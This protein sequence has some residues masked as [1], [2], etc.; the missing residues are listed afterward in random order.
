VLVTT[1]PRAGAMRATGTCAVVVLGDAPAGARPTTDLLAERGPA[2]RLRLAPEQIALLPSSSGTTG[3]P[4]A[5]V[6]THANL[7]AGIAQVQ[8]GFAFTPRDV[9]LGV[10]PFAHVMGFVGALAAPL[11]AGAT[12][13][14]LPRFAPAALLAAI[15]RY[16]VTVLIAPPP[17]AAVLAA[18]PR[19][20]GL[21]SLEFV[22]CGGAPF[23][24]ELQQRLA[25]RLPGAVVG[26]GYGMT[27][28]T[29][30]IPIPDRRDGTPPGSAG[31]LAPGTELRV[32]DPARGDDRPAGEPG[33]LRVRGPQVGRG[34]LADPGATAALFDAHGW[35]CTGDL[36]RVDATGHVHVAGRLKELIKVNALQVAPAELEALLLTR[37]EV[38]DAAVVARPDA[39]SG[40][41]PVA[42]VVPRAALA[43]EELTDWVA[44]RV[45][46]HKR[47]GAVLLAER[48]PRTASGKIL[49]RELR[50]LA[51]AESS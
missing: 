20:A 27:E 8:R 22:V 12:V 51:A 33:E 15:A 42:V 19:A 5:V 21:R 34:Y 41:V 3:P 35:L 29:L 24:P 7:A 4:K 14:C 31:R 37:P 28:T 32:V 44:G 1:P 30:A 10:A 50:A 45:A 18:A 40:E 47:L 46:R 38:A 11:A 36:G 23:P 39:R 26:Q 13:V 43:P 2:P 6:L 49:R 48:I 16:R 25:A 17:V 9:V